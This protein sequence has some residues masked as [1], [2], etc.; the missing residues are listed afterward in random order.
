MNKTP[1]IAEYVFSLSEYALTLCKRNKSQAEELIQ[2]TCELVLRKFPEKYADKPRIE[3]QRL[4]NATMRNLF[5]DKRR[6]VKRK[7]LIL[8]DDEYPY[9]IPYEED[10][11]SIYRT[12]LN[13]IMEFLSASDDPV[14]QTYFLFLNGYK[15]REIAKAKNISINTVVGHNRYAVKRIKK[16]FG[17]LEK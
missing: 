10:V 5:V 7:P 14:F 15:T 11:V 6:A 13:E 17:G 8:G 12:Q 1:N 16:M 2:D 3:Q 9:D 4:V